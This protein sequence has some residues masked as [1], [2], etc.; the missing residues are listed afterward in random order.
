MGLYA[1][2]D[3]SDKVAYESASGDA[4]ARVRVV[5][6]LEASEDGPRSFVWMSGR[7]LLCCPDNK[8]LGVYSGPLENAKILFRADYISKGDHYQMYNA[9]DN[10]IFK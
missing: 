7:R 6:A 2:M 3:V 9:G 5:I 4:D 8:C 1:F 10:L